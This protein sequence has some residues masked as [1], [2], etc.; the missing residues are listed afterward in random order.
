MLSLLF[1]VNCPHVPLFQS[2][3]FS[4]SELHLLASPV[5]RVSRRQ[6][7]KYVPQGVI[8]RPHH[9]FLWGNIALAYTPETNDE[10]GPGATDHRDIIP[11][12]RQ[13]VCELGHTSMVQLPAIRVIDGSRAIQKPPTQPLIRDISTHSKVRR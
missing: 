8:Q 10:P 6:Y 9:Q 13:S 7:V 2:Q 5:R 12:R 1:T 3:A 4:P 11:Y